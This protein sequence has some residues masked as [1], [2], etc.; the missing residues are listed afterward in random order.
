M[1]HY[2]RLTRGGKTCDNPSGTPFPP[3]TA[4]YS[5]DVTGGPKILQLGSQLCHGLLHDRQRPALIVEPIGRNV[6][7][8][9]LRVALLGLCDR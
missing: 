9:L 3:V 1:P 4:P 7:R 2:C 8:W 5:H 6:V